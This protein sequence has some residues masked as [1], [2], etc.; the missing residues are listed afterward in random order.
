MFH[1]FRHH[2]DK[3]KDF[4][5][6]G[7]AHGKAFL[8]RLDNVYRTGKEIY[9]IVSPALHHLAPNATSQATSHLNNFGS[10]YENIK[11]KVVH[12][13]DTVSHHLNDISSKLKSKNIHIGL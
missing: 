10:R 5:G 4:L 7:Y 12:G 11:Q 3:V 9:N 1:S 8:G 6:R 2:Y 13:H